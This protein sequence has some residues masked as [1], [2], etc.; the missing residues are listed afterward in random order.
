MLARLQTR[1]SR[2]VVASTTRRVH[3]TPINRIATISPKAVLAAFFVGTGV[4]Y[5]LQS[6]PTEAETTKPTSIFEFE[7]ERIT[8]EVQSLSEYRGKVC[9]IVNVASKCSA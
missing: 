1:V 6:S 4:A 7:A 2:R 9:L 3:S 5:A 8:G